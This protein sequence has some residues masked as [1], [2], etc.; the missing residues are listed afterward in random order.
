MKEIVNENDL[1]KSSKIKILEAEGGYITDWDQQ[2]ILDFSYATKIICLANKDTSNYYEID[3]Q[4]K[5]RL[6]QLQIT[7]IKELEENGTK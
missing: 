6:E 2:D 3:E 4:E 5:E 1:G 7:R